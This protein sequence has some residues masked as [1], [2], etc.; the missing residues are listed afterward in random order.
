[1]RT[2]PDRKRTQKVE[3]DYPTSDGKPMAETQLHLNEMVDTIQTLDD[4]YAERPRVHVAGNLLLYYEEGNP[5]KHISPDVQVTFGIPKVP[6][7]NYFLV[8]KEGKGPDVAIEITSKTTRRH[9]QGK[10]LEIYR[11]VLK[12]REYFL[13]DPTED[14][15]HPSLQGFQ[16]VGGDYAQIKP[17]GGRLPSKILGLHLERDGEHLRFFDPNMGAWLL[18]R[19]ERAEREH[20]R[21]EQERQRAE[22]AEFAQQRLADEVAR[23]RRENEALRRR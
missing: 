18:R 6:L 2:V 1:M 3:V 10:K 13:F 4:R 15:L 21:A 23:L 9:D 17:V 8:W 20:H 7:R 19:D 11:D 22:A 12:V 16:L 5:R 14:Y